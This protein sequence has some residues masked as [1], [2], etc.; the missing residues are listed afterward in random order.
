MF[1]NKPK[2]LTL[3]ELRKVR[4]IEDVNEADIALLAIAYGVSRADVGD[5]FGTAPAW[6]ALKILQGAWD[7]SNATEDAQFPD[8][9]SDDAQPGGGAE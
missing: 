9:P 4:E 3:P 6:V 2:S 5:W 1:E 8:A 7:A